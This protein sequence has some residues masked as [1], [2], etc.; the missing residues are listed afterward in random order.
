MPRHY[1]DEYA[2][3]DLE[4]S[5]RPVI[6]TLAG[7]RDP[8]YERVTV[9]LVEETPEALAS[10]IAA[11]LETPE[12]ELAAV[13]A[14]ARELTITTRRWKGLAMRVLDFVESTKADRL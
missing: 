13:G 1:Q 11:L 8:E 3:E 14:A 12:K 7:D 10:L 4:A 6:T 5:G 9:P 2:K